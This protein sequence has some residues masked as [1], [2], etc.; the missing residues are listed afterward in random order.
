MVVK[1][2]DGGN[3]FCVDFRKVNTVLVK[4]SYPLPN[5]EDMLTRLGKAKYFTCLDLKSGYWQIKIKED[6]PKT[7]FPCHLGLFE[8]NKMPF[9]L[10]SA[11]LVFSALMDKVLMGAAAYAICYIDDIIIFSET[12]EEHMTHLEDVLG[13]LQK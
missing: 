12:F 13:R 6:K 2:K 8:F 11:P 7:A 10:A 3:R 4:N 5:I 1:K 9:G